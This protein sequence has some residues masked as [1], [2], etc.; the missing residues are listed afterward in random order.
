M[1]TVLAALQKAYPTLS[2]NDIFLSSYME[3]KLKTVFADST[4]MR[5]TR[6]VED[7]NQSTSIA[8]ILFRNMVKLRLE[9]LKEGH[10]MK[11]T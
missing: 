8:E 6:L 4:T 10:D 2:P 1:R 7:D 5:A 9:E 3:S 11:G